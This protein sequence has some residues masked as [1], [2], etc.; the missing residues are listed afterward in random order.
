MC[1]CKYTAVSDHDCKKKRADLFYSSWQPALMCINT[2][3]Y[4]QH[5]ISNRFLIIT[6]IDNTCTV[7]SLIHNVRN[8]TCVC[9]WRQKLAVFTVRPWSQAVINDDL[10]IINSRLVEKL[11]ECS[12]T[13][14]IVRYCVLPC[15]RKGF[16]IWC[17]FFVLCVCVRAS[18]PAAACMRALMRCMRTQAAHNCGHSSL[19]SPGWFGS[20]GRESRPLTPPRLPQRQPLQALIGGMKYCRRKLKGPSVKIIHDMHIYPAWW[21][22]WYLD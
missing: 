12:C 20:A 3:L 7:I 4:F 16:N 2:L 13:A 15:T 1:V 11:T 10:M 6:V 22:P 21:N 18:L 9:V 5:H 8:N 19:L 14:F 17:I